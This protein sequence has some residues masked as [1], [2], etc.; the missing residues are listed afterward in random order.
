V[1]AR[2]GGG[3]SEVVNVGRD[4]RRTGMHAIAIRSAL[5]SADYDD[6]ETDEGGG[7]GATR[8]KGGRYQRM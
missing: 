1:R 2:R 7:V 8:W 3:I 5:T 4:H 6:L